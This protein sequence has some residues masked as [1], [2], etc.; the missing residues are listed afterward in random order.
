MTINPKWQSASAAPSSPVEERLA[1]V[2]L[3]TRESPAGS[4]FEL[5]LLTNRKEA[6]RFFGQ[7]RHRHMPAGITS[8]L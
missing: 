1:V 5:P 8:E 7:A 3:G 4:D 6:T 2:G